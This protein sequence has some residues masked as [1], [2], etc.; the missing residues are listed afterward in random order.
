[1]GD[2]PRR[3]TISEVGP[4]DGLQIEATTVSTADKIALIDKLV[5]AGIDR[6]EVSAFVHP[7][8]VP[9]MADAEQVF[10]GIH[11]RPGVRYGALVPNAKGAE[12]AI[13]AGADDLKIGIAAS[14]TFN[15]VNVRM[16]TEQ[17]VRALDE[18][19]AL[20]RGTDRRLVGVVATAFG[21][22]YEGPVP[23][24]QVER[25]F[26]HLVELGA[27]PIYLADTTGVGNPTSVRRTLAHLRARWPDRQIGLHLHNTRGLGLANALAGIEFGIADFESSIGGLG[28]CPFAPRAVGNISTEDFVHMVHEMGIETG[29][30][31]D[32]LIGVARFAQNVLHRTLPGM[33]MKAG[34]ASE[35]HDR[36]APRMKVD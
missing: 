4:R 8:V 24:A 14:N 1:M 36:N 15:E 16:T 33:V 2:L 32:A 18:I 12:R 20:A 25:L 3:I 5:A 10:A 19:V 9:Q 22:P 27:D 17:G 34:K 29:I 31:L 21:C 30:D 23:L 35:L 11:R 13:A 28:G 7:K 26:A 6:I